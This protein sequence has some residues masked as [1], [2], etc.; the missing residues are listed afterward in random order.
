M[1][2]F[3]ILLKKVNELANLSSEVLL[4]LIDM[5]SNADI[6]AHA[7]EMIWLLT[8]FALACIVGYYVISRVT[9]SLHTPLMSVT[10]AICGIIVIGSLMMVGVQDHGSANLLG[11]VATILASINIFGGFVV[12]WRMLKMFK[13][14][15]DHA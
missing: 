6:N 8:I 15:R 12:T 10:N 13:S 2:D 1:N 11:S 14:K 5:K 7:G 4:R 3:D 9:P